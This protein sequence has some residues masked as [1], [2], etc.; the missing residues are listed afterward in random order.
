MSWISFW[1][2]GECENVS[3]ESLREERWKPF[4][5]K[6]E[7]QFDPI[8]SVIILGMVFLKAQTYQKDIKS[9]YINQKK[10]IKLR[11]YLEE[12]RIEIDAPGILQGLGR[13]LSG[14]SREELECLRKHLIKGLK[15]VYLSQEKD[16]E[17]LTA[18]KTIFT[19]AAKGIHELETSYNCQIINEEYLK[20]DLKINLEEEVL[21]QIKQTG[22]QSKN[23]TSRC[24]EAD[25]KF[26]EFIL[27]QS[28]DEAKKTILAEDAQLFALQKLKINSNSEQTI[29]EYFASK[30][31]Q[32]WPAKT[33]TGI[34]HIFNTQA[35]ESFDP[36]GSLSSFIEPNP[37]AFKKI[38]KEIHNMTLAALFR[39]LATPS[40]KQSQPNPSTPLPPTSVGSQNS[41]KDGHK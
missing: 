33:L 29:E 19:Y 35:N 26:I 5:Q 28:L 40:S 13:Q 30:I 31:Q 16:S 4:L 38:A 27:K 32:R 11:L 25:R 22:L 15:W 24:L 8:Y 12:H 9:E 21:S 23:M 10:W 3:Q 7:L 36:I 17:C 14:H 41:K 18:L 39:P 2:T 1:A 20:A 34:A 37:S 6:Q